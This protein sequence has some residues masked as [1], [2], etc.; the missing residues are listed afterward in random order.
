M[1]LVTHPNHK[2]S[3]GQTDVPL[4]QFLPT[5]PKRAALLNEFRVTG[6]PYA[7]TPDPEMMASM[8][9]PTMMRMPI[10]G[11]ANFTQSV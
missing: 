9:A 3:E 11:A 1:L 5:R 8:I 7:N 2:K 10:S 4:V 6:F